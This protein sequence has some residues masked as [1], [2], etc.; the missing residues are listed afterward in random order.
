M[1]MR[2]SC[3]SVS[4][5]LGGSEVALLRMVTALERLHPD[6]QFQIVLPG[7]GPLRA[8]LNQTRAVCSVVA[9]P[10]ALS[11]L[12]EWAAVQDGWRTGSQV[13]LGI[14]L[15]GTAA[16]LPAYE[17]RLRR[18]ISEFHPHVIH[19]NGLKAHVLGA[20]LGN[21]QAGLV[22]HL[23]EY[24]SRRKLTR[25]L[26]RRY[27]SRCSAIVAN[28]TSVARDVACSIG[29][30]PDVHVVANPVD[31]DV[32]APTGTRL[33]LDR[34]AGLPAAPSGAT[35]VGLVAT[36]ARWKGHEVFL[37]AMKQ[38][39]LRSSIRGYIIGGP[40]YDT[41]NSQFTRRELQT[42]ID[43]RDLVGCVGLTGFVEPAPAMRAL[44]V[45]VHASTE[46]EPF[47]LV[48]AE[49]MACG[50]PVVTTG[51]G[52]AAELV[53]HG[54][55]ALVA[56]SGEAGVL[57][58]AIQN[59]ATNPALRAAIGQRA[60]ETALARFAPTAVASQLGRV[61]ETISFRSAVAQSA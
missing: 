25:W 52:G 24:I 16:A 19:T 40:I 43:S 14:K 12:G 20:R 33:D 6:W 26:L 53:A 35:R 2:I 3:L 49:A 54:H 60:R 15:C 21:R 56:A 50:R 57:A 5:Q 7:D 37:D 55:D 59:L 27:A 17:S 46:P 31:L 1:N 42:M 47:G 30:K 61:F 34:L 18:V 41:P 22:W 51:E 8:S 28:S 39:A 4:D 44:D 58:D 9:M 45:L 29:P 48:I 32:F 10:A 11:Q 23:H 38:L 13:A 36:Y